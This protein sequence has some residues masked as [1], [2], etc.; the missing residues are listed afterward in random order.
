VIRNEV[1][2]HNCVQLGMPSPFVATTKGFRKAYVDVLNNA[3]DE[4]KK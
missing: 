4:L 3:I 1:A 2:V